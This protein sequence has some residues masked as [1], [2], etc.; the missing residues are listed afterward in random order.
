MESK[1]VMAVSRCVPAEQNSRQGAALKQ[2]Y[3][4]QGSFDNTG[5]N[6]VVATRNCANDGEQY[7]RNGLAKRDHSVSRRRNTIGGHYKLSSGQTLYAPGGAS[8]GD[9]VWTPR[10]INRT[11]HMEMTRDH[12][13]DPDQGLEQ[14]DYMQHNMASDRDEVVGPAIE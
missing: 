1:Q 4:S 12:V 13:F 10:S 7:N 5:L 14:Y 6:G 8:V 2:F 11:L 9:I 3:N